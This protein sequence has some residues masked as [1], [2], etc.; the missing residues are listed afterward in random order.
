MLPLAAIIGAIGAGVNAALGIGTLVY[1]ISAQQT[2][3]NREDAAQQRAV[4]DMRAAG[5][6]P[7]L[8]AGSGSQ[9]STQMIKGPEIE[10]GKILGLKQVEE[11]IN[12]TKL[13][14]EGLSLDNKYKEEF[15][16]ARNIEKRSKADIS[17]VNKE[18]AQKTKNYV[19]KIKE[20]KV[21]EAD[22]QA[23]LKKWQASM[24]KHKYDYIFIKDWKDVADIFAKTGIVVGGFIL[25]KTVMD[26]RKKKMILMEA[27]IAELESRAEERRKRSQ[28]GF[29]KERVKSMEMNNETVEKLKRLLGL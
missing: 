6:S 23:Q 20:H 29:W 28:S 25:G 26:E 2:Q 18:I 12:K 19:I 24:A 15:L 17:I 11:E 22:Y 13:E 3:W 14:N 27:Q 1:N 4:A 21:T 5:L 16:E 9:S 10:L 7:T 8:A